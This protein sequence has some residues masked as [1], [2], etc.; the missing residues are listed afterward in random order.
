M[1]RR[2]SGFLL[3]F[4]YLLIWSWANSLPAQIVLNEATMASQAIAETDAGPEYNY[5]IDNFDELDEPGSYS[6]VEYGSAPGYYSGASVGTEHDSDLAVG[7]FE[8]TGEAYA[9][10]ADDYGYA[11]VSADSQVAEYI[12]F[13]LPGQTRIQILG[14]LSFSGYPAQE[15]DAY[16]ALRRVGQ[17]NLYQVTSAGDIEFDEVL[18]AGTYQLTV[19]SRVWL[20]FDFSG[21][22]L[23][24]F[25]R[26][27]FQVSLSATA[28]P[29]SPPAF[30]NVRHRIMAESADEDGSDADV[31]TSHA[32]GSF[33]AE[34]DVSTPAVTSIASLNSAVDAGSG[35]FY[36]Y[37]YAA[38]GL[39]VQGTASSD[40]D[41]HFYTTFDLDRPGTL[42]L[43]GEV[44][45]V[46]FLGLYQSHDEPGFARVI[47]RLQDL[48][49]GG[50]VLNKVITMNGSV[51]RKNVADLQDL[52]PSVE[53]HPGRYR[54]TVRAISSDG[55]N[56][57]EVA[58]SMAV[59]YLEV[60]GRIIE[61][62]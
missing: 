12:T 51:P 59:G 27:T 32:F 11:Y 46:D 21:G 6:Y 31:I 39:Y 44:G 28:Q 23:Y 8:L 19:L 9:Y 42:E 40:A 17:A 53:L 3:V 18:P 14:S 5:E 54:L 34:A 26:G 52:F 22:D 41:S 62:Q 24:E 1:E 13:T 7:G 20:E 45:V 55:A 29:F 30:V 38:S 43:Q 15:A 57:A 47:V 48:T 61:Q 36:V 50:N 10:T 2:K 60:E 16:F 58:G 33:V 4:A 37:G 35:T 25:S 56:N 49:H